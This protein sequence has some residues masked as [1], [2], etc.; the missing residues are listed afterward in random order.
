MYMCIGVCIYVYVYVYIYI[1]VC[2]CIYIYSMYIYIYIYIY[3]KKGLLNA[4]NSNP[5]KIFNIPPGIRYLC[6]YIFVS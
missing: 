1:C 3:I 4:E 6:G 2:M 5:S